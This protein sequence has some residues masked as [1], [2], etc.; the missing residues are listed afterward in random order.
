MKPHNMLI[1]KLR[2]AVKNKF[3]NDFVKLVKNSGF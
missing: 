2:T 3:Q 1:T